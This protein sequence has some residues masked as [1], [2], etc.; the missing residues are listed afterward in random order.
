MRGATW[1]GRYL[2]GMFTGIPSAGL[3]PAANTGPNALLGSAT[4]PIPSAT[5]W[6]GP[7]AAIPTPSGSPGIWRID[8][9][10][11]FNQPDYWGTTTQAYA[12]SNSPANL[13][14][15]IPAGGMMIDGYF[16]AAGTYVFQ[17]MD[18]SAGGFVFADWSTALGGPAPPI[19]VMFRG[20]RFREADSGGQ[21]YFGPIDATLN[22]YGYTGNLAFHF[23][24]FGGKGPSDVTADACVCPFSVGSVA[25]LRFLRCYFSYFGTATHPNIFQPGGASGYN[26]TFECFFEK[27]CEYPNVYP[28]AHLNGISFNG[29]NPNALVLR[30]SLV[31]VTPDEDGNAIIDTDCI[32]FFQ[33]GSPQQPY[34]GNGTNSDGSIGYYVNGNYVGGTGWCFYF[35]QNAGTAD[36][37]LNNMHAYGNWVTTSVWA[38]GTGDPE[39]TLLGGGYHGAAADVPNKG[40]G[41]YGN[42]QSKNL[43]AD[44]PLAGVSFL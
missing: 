17:F 5:S 10:L 38:W 42:I 11:G 12:Y 21:G 8:S 9:D 1:D 7:P 30:N 39:G 15:I 3:N 24:E 6:T 31:L 41:P 2:R 16:Y 43:W 14:G 28:G 26:D 37:T 36:N 23:C 32:S 34:P 29:G 13:G 35:G 40:W 27:V 25:N 44:G 20:C 4:Y 22:N 18:L 33:D 19:S